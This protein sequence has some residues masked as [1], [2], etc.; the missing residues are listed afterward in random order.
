MKHRVEIR[1]VSRRSD[2]Y[3]TAYDGRVIGSW[4]SPECAAARWLLEQGLASECDVLT[5]YRGN[6]PCLSGEIGWFAN[7]RPVGSVELA[8]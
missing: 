3:E 8:G 6:A 5:T 2:L 1:R 7:K 4:R